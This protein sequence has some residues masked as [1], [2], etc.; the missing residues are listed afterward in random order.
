MPKPRAFAAYYLHGVPGE[1]AVTVQNHLAR[2]N[3]EMAAIAV[4]LYLSG[5]TEFTT[6]LPLLDPKLVLRED[7]P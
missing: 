6:K 5:K 7:T 2:G 3:H 1:L 4:R